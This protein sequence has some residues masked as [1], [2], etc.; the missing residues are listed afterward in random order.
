[1][2]ETIGQ[3][4]SYKSL[5]L[6][7]T[8]AH[9]YFFYSAD[10]ELN[11]NIALFFAK[12]LICDNQTGCNTCNSCRMFLSA[13]HPD[14]FILDKDA[15]KVEDANNLIN[16]LATKPIISNKKVYIILNAENVNEISQ[17]KLLKSLEEPNENSVFVLTSSKTDKILPTILSRMSKIYVPK[18]SGA[19]KVIIKDELIKNGVDISKYIDAEISLTD[20]MDISCNAEHLQTINQISNLLHS[21]NTSADIPIATHKLENFNKNI[22]FSIMQDLFISCLKDGKSKF[23]GELVSFVKASYSEKAIIRCIAHIEKAYTMQKSN[24]NF[25]Y[26]LENLL[27]N[28]LKEKFLC[29]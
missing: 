24:V 14:V 8:F 19:D 2:L 6:D 25:T 28:M 20:L 16:K 22:F 29:K 17:N 4:S 15:I 5:N 21:L 3:T 23:G 18:L 12:K 11:N 26:I 10:K 27:F 7:K 9:A 1:M 13:S